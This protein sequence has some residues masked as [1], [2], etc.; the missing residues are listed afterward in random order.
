MIMGHTALHNNTWPQHSNEECNE[1]F[2]ASQP[3]GHAGTTC[4][5]SVLLQVRQIFDCDL[6]MLHASRRWRSEPTGKPS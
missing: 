4:F 3:K 2:E 5:P 1:G 6:I